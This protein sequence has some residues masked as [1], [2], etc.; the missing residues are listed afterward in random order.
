MKQGI[1]ILAVFIT[2]LLC[3]TCVVFARGMF[4]DMYPQA[5]QLLAPQSE[6]IDLSG[7]DFLEFRWVPLTYALI[8]H[9]EF[10]LY[11]GNNTY[12]SNLVLK[13]DIAPQ[14]SSF[15]AKS[16]LFETGKNYIWSLRL[17]NT[18]GIKGDIATD[19]FQIIKK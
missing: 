10:R 2:F 9:Y 12:G 17:V 19:S 13:Q 16:G 5:P 14:E 18:R 6:N 7:K 3:A 11:S 15:Q 4:D 8:D 1:K